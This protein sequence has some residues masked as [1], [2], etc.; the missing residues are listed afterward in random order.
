MLTVI[1]TAT[2]VD[3][4]G[5]PALSLTT[6]VTLGKWR[7]RHVSSSNCIIVIGSEPGPT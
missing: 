2:E 4:I 3:C 6:C 1:V 7:L 5:D